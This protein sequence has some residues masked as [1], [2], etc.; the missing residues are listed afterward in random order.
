MTPLLE[1]AIEEIQKLSTPEQDA[2]AGVILD[3]LADEERWDEAFTRSQEQ[4]GRL[5]AKAREDIRAG[6]VRDTPVEDPSNQP[7]ANV[8]GLL[9][10]VLRVKPTFHPVPSQ[11]RIWYSGLK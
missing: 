11:I 3:E 5:A 2:I 6:K 10:Y 9:Q 7:S 4:L 1:R 8:N